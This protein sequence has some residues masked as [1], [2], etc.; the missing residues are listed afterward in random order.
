MRF[1]KEALREIR[2]HPEAHVEAQRRIKM[3]EYCIQHL[4]NASYDDGEDLYCAIPMIA[5]LNG[6]RCEDI[7][8]ECLKGVSRNCGYA[9]TRQEDECGNE[10]KAYHIDVW[11]KSYPNCVY[12]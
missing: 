6:L 10:M 5:K 2:E 4:E 7:D 9:V 12:V 8:E 1:L 11:R 3:L